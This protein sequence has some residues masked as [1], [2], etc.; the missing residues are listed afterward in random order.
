MNAQISATQAESPQQPQPEPQDGVS[1]PAL[2]RKPKGKI[3]Q[4]PRP[5]RDLINKLLADGA[6]YAVVAAE[7][8]KHEVS[9]NA[10]N[11]SNWYQSG[12]QE[13]LQ[14]QDWLTQVNLLREDAADVPD[15]A[16]MLLHQAV[17]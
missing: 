14:H 7:M 2:S 11:I 10:E 16:N 9:L 5:Q 8:T 6:T 3:A 15:P 4:L 17:L 12:F 13:Y 1:P